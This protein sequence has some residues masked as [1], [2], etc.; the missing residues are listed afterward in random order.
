MVT[1]IKT[2]DYTYEQTYQRKS[3][4]RAQNVKYFMLYLNIMQ[5]RTLNIAFFLLC[6]WPFLNT[7]TAN[8]FINAFQ[9]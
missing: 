2:N 3:D 1:I 9:I 4:L 5:I 6:L 8:V 7:V